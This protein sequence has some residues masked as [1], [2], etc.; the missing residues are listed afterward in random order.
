VV[1]HKNASDCLTGLTLADGALFFGSLDASVYAI[2]ATT[3]TFLWSRATG[4]KVESAP[5]VD[6]NRV[7]VGSFDGTVYA[8]R[9]KNGRVVWKHAADR[10]FQRDP[11]VVLDGFVYVPGD[12]IQVL[13]ESTGQLDHSMDVSAGRWAMMSSSLFVGGTGTVA[14]YDDATGNQ[15]W[16]TSTGGSAAVEAAPVTANGLVLA[17]DVQGYLTAFDARTGQRLLRLATGAKLQDGAPI[18]VNGKVYTVDDDSDSVTAF[19]L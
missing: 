10:A 18:V 2:D 17:I 5:S 12:P 16:S 19:G 11:T 13:D 9:E 1:W 3:G 14:A 4:D 15:L 7:F 6:D 8:L